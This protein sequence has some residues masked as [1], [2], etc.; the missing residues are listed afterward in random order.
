MGRG[1]FQ[2]SFGL[3]PRRH[4][5]TTVVG[6][7]IIVPRNPNPSQIEIDDLHSK[8][9]DALTKVFEDNK[10]KYLKNADKIRLIIEWLNK[11]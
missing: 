4:P 11:K 10:E 7:P 3:I 9:V 6:A 2:Y 1:F 8:F 5:I